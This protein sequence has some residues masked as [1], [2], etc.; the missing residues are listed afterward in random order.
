MMQQQVSRRD[1]ARARALVERRA[2]GLPEDAQAGIGVIG[3]SG[4][5]GIGGLRDVVE[6]RP[7]TPFGPPSDALVVG[8]LGSSRVAFL[9][10]HGRGHRLTPT[11]VPYRANLY[12]LKLLGVERVVAVSACGSM[13][14]AIEPRDL[15][16]P[17]QVVDRTTLRPNTFFGRGIVVHVGFAD[18][19]CPVLSRRL[20]DDAEAVLA[21]S[22]RRV[23]RGGAYLTIEGPQFSTRAEA[24]VHRSWGVSVVGMTGSPEARLARE[25]ELCYAMLAF[26]TDFDV[27]HA[28]AEDVSVAQVVANVEANVVAARRIVG[29]LAE[30]PLPTDEQCGCAS[31]LAGAVQTA[32]DAMDRARARELALLLG[33]EAG[34]P[35]SDPAGGGPAA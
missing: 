3:G 31:A 26:A 18:P 23:H 29:S 35:G 22:G 12:A 16:I 7:A 20:A 34:D 28:G 8:T 10:R 9:P 14:E 32:R 6:V 19:F 33:P 21:A 17:D 25:A 30:R 2:L 13:R 27:W 4:L 11:E 15:V 5:Y 1:E 24:A